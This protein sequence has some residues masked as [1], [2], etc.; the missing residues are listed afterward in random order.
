MHARAR[1]QSQGGG[2]KQIIPNARW[3][4]MLT[5]MRNTPG[6]GNDIDEID[7]YAVRCGEIYCEQVEKY[8][9]AR[10]QV[11]GR[12]VSCFRERAVW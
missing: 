2:F 12:Y 4:E 11:P 3:E 1:G 5:I 10:R 6:F 9:N 8:T 7:K